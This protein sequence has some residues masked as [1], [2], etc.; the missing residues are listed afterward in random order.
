M[1]K[2]SMFNVQKI[3]VQALKLSQ[4]GRPLVVG[5]SIKWQ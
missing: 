5:P 2:L 4:Y 3:K 1:Q